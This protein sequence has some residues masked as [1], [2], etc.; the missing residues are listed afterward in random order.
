TLVTSG[1]CT[2]TGSQYPGGSL[3]L[4][5]PCVQLPSFA[6]EFGNGN[7]IPS[8]MINPAAQAIQKFFP[9]PNVD[10]TMTKSGYAVN[11][12]AYNTPSSNPF[13]KFFGRL[14]WNI[15]QNNRFTASA[16]ES[17]NPATYLNQGLC[18]INCQHGDVSRDNAQISD[19]WTIS[20]RFINEA[21]M[22]FTDQLNFFTPYSIGQGWIQKLGMPMLIADE[23]PNVGI[24]NFYGL[25]SSS[26]AVY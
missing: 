2:Y 12:Y 20:S 9:S 14:D 16:T 1:N 10:G 7:K 8:S 5:A 26:N 11:N 6:Q 15:T 13:T 3:T 19:V 4:P 21:R 25:G 23:F 24:S 17:D 22:G 18:P